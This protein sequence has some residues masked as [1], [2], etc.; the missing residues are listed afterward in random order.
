MAFVNVQYFYYSV[1]V[2][3]SFMHFARQLYVIK[4]I[5]C[6]AVHRLNLEDSKYLSHMHYIQ[7]QE[8]YL[9]CNYLYF[10]ANNSFVFNI[11]GLRE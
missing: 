10:D 3:F 7:N 4:N 6:N 1:I 8:I 11:L 5:L 2:Y 9:N